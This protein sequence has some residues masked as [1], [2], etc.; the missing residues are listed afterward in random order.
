MSRLE[1]ITLDPSICHGKPTVRGLISGRKPVGV[2][3][4][5]NDDR[6]DHRRPSRSRARRSFGGAR[7]RGAGVRSAPGAARRCVKFLIDAQLPAR[8]VGLLGAAGHDAVIRLSFPMATG[9]QMPHSPRWRTVGPSRPGGLILAE[10]D[11][12]IAVA[13]LAIADKERQ[14]LVNLQHRYVAVTPPVPSPSRTTASAQPSATPHAPPATDTC[15]K[16]SSWPSIPRGEA[17]DAQV[18]SR[19]PRP[20]VASRT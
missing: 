13:T 11:Q 5:G 15:E 18:P 14:D 12:P 19:R 16:R 17:Q 2:V 7:L 20:A 1:R 9:R 4:V 8:L 3:G 6:G 10:D